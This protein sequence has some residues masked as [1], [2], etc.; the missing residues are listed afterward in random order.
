MPAIE[1]LGYAGVLQVASFH[2]QF[3]S[4]DT[5]ADDVTNATNRSPYP[6]C[7]CCARRAST[8][9]GGL[10]GAESIYE[11]NMRTLRALGRKVGR[12]CR[13]SAASDAGESDGREPL[14]PS[15]AAGSGRRL[16]LMTRRGLRRAVTCRSP[17]NCVA[18]T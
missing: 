3:S 2:P 15:P 9:R 6:P 11:A 18:G 12:A 4:P 13:R 8:G 5:A 16:A 14:R 1:A 10:P 17:V 7:I